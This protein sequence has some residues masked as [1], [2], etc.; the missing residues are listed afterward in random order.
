MRRIVNL[1]SRLRNSPFRTPAHLMTVLRQVQLVIEPTPPYCAR[2]RSGRAPFIQDPTPQTRLVC[3]CLSV[4]QF[5]DLSARTEALV[6]H[7]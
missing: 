6:T 4:T 1:T 2:P 7:L 3:V 5:R